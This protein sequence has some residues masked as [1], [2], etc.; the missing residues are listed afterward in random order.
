M[1]ST[2]NIE[3]QMTR[4]PIPFSYLRRDTKS[5]QGKRKED[6]VSATIHKAEEMLYP[7]MRDLNPDRIL[8][9]L[10]VSALEVHGHHLPMGMD[11]FFASLNASDLAEAF[12]RAHPDW[13]VDDLSCGGN[14]G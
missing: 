1:Q 9:I 5:T 11:P 7:Q 12:A 3:L 8:L 13:S 10:P 6:G 2:G 4:N 14:E